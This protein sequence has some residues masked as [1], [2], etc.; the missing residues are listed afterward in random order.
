[1]KKAPDCLTDDDTKKGKLISDVF[2]LTVRNRLGA[3]VVKRNIFHRKILLESA[4]ITTFH[5]IS[6]NRNVLD[7]RVS[8]THK[9]MGC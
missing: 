1:M 8:L 4:T 6:E 3:F 2:S 9:C 5:F 7:R